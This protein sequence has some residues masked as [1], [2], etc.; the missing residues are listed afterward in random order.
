LKKKEQ[1]NL[2]R[3]LLEI[4]PVKNIE[5]GTYPDSGLVFL[6]QP[7]FRSVLLKKYL[8][9]RLPDQFY[10]V[11]L[12]DIGSFIWHEIDGE[13][14]VSGIAVAVEREFGTRVDPVHQRLGTFI[15]SLK[16]SR[17]IDYRPDRI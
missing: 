3:N 15:R 8:L 17:F 11:N 9:H 16:R 13:Q 10:R 7:K 14:N 4:I 1:I 2:N 12:D 5:W 6:K